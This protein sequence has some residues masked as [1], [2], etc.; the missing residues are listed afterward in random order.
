[1]FKRILVPVDFSALSQEAVSLAAAL[2]RA[3][4]S[5]E[6]L[7]VGV[8]PDPSLNGD[9]GPSASLQKLAGEMAG[10]RGAALDALRRRLVPSDVSTGIHLRDGSPAAEIVAAAQ[11]LG[12]DLV[13][14]GTHGRVGLE[15]FLLGSVAE[16][17]VRLSPVPVM[18]TRGGASG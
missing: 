7:S 13:V 6:L 14:M 2:C 9:S 8:L 1:M 18:L 15:H 16:R 17:V 5:L 10:S 12:C 4:G 3:G 11:E